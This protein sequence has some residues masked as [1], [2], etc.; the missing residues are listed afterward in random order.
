MG[1]AVFAESNKIHRTAAVGVWR[2][3]SHSNTN[4]MHCEDKTF[5]SVMANAKITKM[6]LNK[7]VPQT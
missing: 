5:A 1:S 4:P 3:E 2:P 6:Q 7:I